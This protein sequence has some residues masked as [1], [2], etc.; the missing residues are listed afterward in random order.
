MN[1][2]LDLLLA[3]ESN[4]SQYWKIANKNP[5]VSMLGLLIIVFL[6]FRAH[7]YIGVHPLYI[8]FSNRLMP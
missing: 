7:Y 5:F 4:D 1:L 8:Y 3:V 6:D 2:F